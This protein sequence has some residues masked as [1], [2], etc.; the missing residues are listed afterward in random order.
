MDKHVM[1]LQN[2]DAEKHLSDVAKNFILPEE[3]DFDLLWE[4]QATY[5][6]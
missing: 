2:N 5:E 6:T 1:S 4:F 3:F